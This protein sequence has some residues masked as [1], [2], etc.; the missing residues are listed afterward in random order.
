MRLLLVRHGETDLNKQGR[1]QG[2]YGAPLNATGRAQARAL[3]AA[4]YENLPFKLYTSPVARALETAQIIADT[5]GVPLTPL[6][7]LQEADAGELEGLTGQEMRRRYPDFAASWA[8]DSGTTRM[9][10]G[11]TLLQVQERAWRAIA[12]LTENHPDVAVV[13]VTHNFT[14]Q[15]ILCT[16]LEMP[17]RNG[18]RL[19]P[20]LGSI[21][22]LNLSP[23][24]S[25]LLSLN[26]TWHLQHL[27]LSQERPAY[28]Q[29]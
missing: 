1:I 28:E 17:L 14:I 7:G 6:A 13:A 9:P 19:R 29:H 3:A 2:I 27:E 11:E 21:T 18:R 5:L 23:S 15:T 25:S 26:E 10:G 16:M 20:N 4:L 22:R 8:R 24:E 12:A